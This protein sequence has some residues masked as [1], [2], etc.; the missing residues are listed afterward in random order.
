MCLNLHGNYVEKQSNKVTF[1]NAFTPKSSYF[2]G[3]LIMYTVN[4]TSRSK[5]TEHEV[6]QSRFNWLFTIHI[7]QR[8]RHL[9]VAYDYNGLT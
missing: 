9:L 3:I 7:F 2:L 5:I 6:K 4:V 8:A 1:S